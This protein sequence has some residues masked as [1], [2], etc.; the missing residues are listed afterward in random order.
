MKQS[1]EQRQLVIYVVTKVWF[2]PFTHSVTSFLNNSL[3]DVPDL[4]SIFNLTLITA[5]SH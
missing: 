2:Q 3:M 5:F 1:L 4:V